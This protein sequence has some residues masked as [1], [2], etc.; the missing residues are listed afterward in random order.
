MAEAALRN[1]SVECFLGRKFL[2][3][4]KVNAATPVNAKKLANAEAKE[5]GFN[6]TQFEVQD[7]TPATII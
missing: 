1:Y 3:A 4:T 6:P 5:K 2:Y 7:I